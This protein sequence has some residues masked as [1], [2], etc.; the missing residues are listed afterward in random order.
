LRCRFKPTGLLRGT[1]P[2]ARS[3]TVRIIINYGNSP[4]EQDAKSYWRLRAEA[5]ELEP[6]AFSD[7]PARHAALTIDKV[8]KRLGD[9]RSKRK[10]MLGVFENGN[11]IGMAGFFRQ[12]GEKVCHRGEI[13]SVYLS[14][15]Y[16]NKGVGRTLLEEVIRQAQSQP[17]LEQI[18][19]GV[20][21]VNVAAKRL[22]ESLGFAIYGCEK[23]ALKIGNE[24][25][26]EE[27]MVLHFVP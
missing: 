21:A 1:F 22:Y 2:P 14:R 18:S 13:R 6:Q 27:L 11:L 12:D 10:F 17:G 16:R 20:S 24:Y 3:R 8:R 4:T 9:G 5:L 7:D 15:Q 26:D 25:I 19:L 23:R